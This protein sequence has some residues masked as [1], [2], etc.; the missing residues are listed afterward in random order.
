MNSTNLTPLEILQM[1]KKRLKSKSD[2]LVA[3]VKKN[4]GYLSDN[5]I[6]LAGSSA[7]S[8]IAGGLSDLLPFFL[9]GRKGLIAG[10]LLRQIQKVLF[11]K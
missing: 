10:L 3:E 7:V 9:K 8:A 6:P 5:I 4:A 1:R 11:R 2:T